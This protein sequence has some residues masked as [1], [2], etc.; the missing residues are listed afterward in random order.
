MQTMYA[1]L[2]GSIVQLSLPSPDTHLL[3]DVRWGSFDHLLTPAYWKGQ[4]WQHEALGTYADARLGRSLNEEVAACLLG[5]YGMPAEMGL[6][7]YRRLRDRELLADVPTIEEV[8][9]ALAE[10]LFTPQGKPRRYRFPRQKAHYLVACLEALRHIDPPTEDLALRNLLMTLP[11]IG[12]KTASWIV[13]NHRASDAVAIIDVHI[14]RACRHIGLF[15]THW[16]PLRHYF[17]LESAFIEFASALD[18]RPAMLD[19][20]MW[21]YMRRLTV[22]GAS[23]TS[24]DRS[25]MNPLSR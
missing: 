25:A 13:R 18:I 23:E 20:L 8:E 7:A 10:P 9:R 21:D 14:L 24:L 12:A 6:A 17:E 4:A 16:D 19:A 1:V 3:R 2:D 22:A 15:Q 11:G 5:G